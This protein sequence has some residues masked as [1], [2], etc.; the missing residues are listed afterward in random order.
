MTF[1]IITDFTAGSDNINIAALNGTGFIA[2]SGTATGVNVTTIANGYNAS[3]DFTSVNTFSDLSSELFGQL[4]G[5]SGGGASAS[6]GVQA[7]LIDL[8]GNTGLLG[9]GSYL[10]INDNDTDLTASDLMIA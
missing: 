6:T 3:V 9:T 2:G 4:I 8:A 7:Y 5:S 1:D 10:V